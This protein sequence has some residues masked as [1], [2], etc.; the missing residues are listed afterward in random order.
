[1]KT[2]GKPTDSNPWVPEAPAIGPQPA[3]GN[4]KR[5]SG[6][7]PDGRGS[8]ADRRTRSDPFSEIASL[9][10]TASSRK[11]LLVRAFRQIAECLGSAY[12]AISVREGA[13]V[14]EEHWHSGPTDPKFWRG[15]IERFLTESLGEGIAR[16]ELLNPKKGSTR[17]ALLS[18]PVTDASGAVIGCIALVV[19]REGEADAMHRLALLESLTRFMSFVVEHAEAAGIAQSRSAAAA[20]DQSLARSSGFKTPEELAFAMTNNLRNKIGAEQVAL[21]LVSHRR[22]NILSVSGLDSVATRSQ[23]IRH[24]RAAMEECLDVDQPIVCQA[25]SSWSCEIYSSGHWLH[26]QWHASAKGAAVASIP[27]HAEGRVAAVLSFRRRADETVTSELIEEIRKRAE[28]FAPSLL[29]I[30]DANRG[31]WQHAVDSAGNAVRAITKPGRVTARVI[32]V[33]TVIAACWFAFG[34]MTY[35]LTVPC[36]IVAA[37]SR[38]ATAPFDGVLEFVAVVEGDRVV[39]GQTLCRFDRRPLEQARAE[40]I[41]EIA[42]LE[43]EKDRALAG[44]SPVDFQLALANQ[45]L[46]RTRLN[47]LEARMDRAT[48]VSPLDGVVIAGD[49]R[50]KVGAVLVK[51]EPLFEIA[52]LSSCILQLQIPQRDVDDVAQNMSGEFAVH[53]RPEQAQPMHII[54]VK[55]SAEVTGQKTVYVAE[56]VMDLNREDPSL[57]LTALR[58]WMRPGMEGVAKVQVGRR[59]VWWVAFHRMIDYL[60]MNVWL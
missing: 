44:A 9:A 10:R 56:A 32:A 18:A 52:P 7:L 30:R 39:S 24:L 47:S 55:P 16:A 53:A 12:A 17:V 38:H 20:P 13:T 58:E 28:P 57:A 27:L 36:R 2:A 26:K 25:E 1:M 33:L 8:E 31:L 42:V 45:K 15:T 43:R 34:S 19:T 40:I 48:V 54:R 59:P 4:V 14:I 37:Q 60:R 35:E 22:V 5:H 41:A 6:A 3:Q 11:E 23:G 46:A 51:G 21:G 49:L 29:L 50:Q